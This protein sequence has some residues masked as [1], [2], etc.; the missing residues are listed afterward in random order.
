MKKQD[1]I[2]Q[3]IKSLEPNERRYFRLFSS[4][5]QGEKKYLQL[6]DML[7]GQ[8]EYDAT[9]L[10]KQ[11]GMPKS[12]LAEVKHYLNDAILNSL[13]A[14]NE[15]TTQIAALY[16][17]KEDARI[18]LS[19]R[20]FLQSLEVSG[21]TAERARELEQFELLIE[22][23]NIRH[24]TYYNLQLFEES[25]AVYDEYKQVVE[26]ENEVMQ[27]YSLKAKASGYEVL[28]NK[29]AEFEKL[30]EHPL[31]KAGPEKLKSLRAKAVWFDI[32]YYYYIAS[33]MPQKAL[34]ISRREWQCYAGNPI[35]KVSNGTAYIIS[36]TRLAYAEHTTG[37][38]ERALELA[39]ELKR[40]LTDKT[41]EL[42]KA[43]RTTFMAYN[44]SFRMYVLLRLE[45]FAEVLRES[46]AVIE[47]MKV[48]PLPE[49]YASIFNYALALVHASAHEKAIDELNKL[50][51]INTD[52]R[53]D[54]QQLARLLMVMVHLDL[55]NNSL[56]PH[57]IKAARSWM[58]RHSYANETVNGL[59]RYFL[60][61][62]HA[63][64]PEKRDIYGKCLAVIRKGG[65]QPMAGTLML[66]S[67]LEKRT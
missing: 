56:I 36:H 5:Q 7:E 10:S 38:N 45:R 19:R 18:L 8:D 60:L 64:A 3:L 12:R 66:S 11:L 55:G 31:I 24:I 65:F 16:V 47:L 59:Y 53:L 32:M 54:L 62:S 4:L 49:Q 2:I 50:V 41:R 1:Y 13:R 22:L 39:E 48:R 20:L 37:N 28:R 46:P 9:A 40:V 58:K 30:C 14:T 34:E 35:I 21:K 33:D 26:I 23:L 27:I 61:A 15:Q 67:W 42:S 43:R 52:V 57:L 51:D 63:P 29:R 6:F 25:A 44:E 17:A